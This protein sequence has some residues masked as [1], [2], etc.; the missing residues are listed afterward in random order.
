MPD[1]PLRREGLLVQAGVR[2]TGAAGRPVIHDPLDGVSA[3]ATLGAAA[4]AGIDLAHAGPLRLFCD[5]RPHLMVAERIARTDDHR[6][7]LTNTS[8]SDEDR[9]KRDARPSR[10]HDELQSAHLGVAKRPLAD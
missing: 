4:E 8:E 2:M 3:A 9:H 6:L 5:H 1:H 10:H 7:L